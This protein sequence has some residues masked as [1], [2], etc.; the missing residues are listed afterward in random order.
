V[1]SPTAS[2]S[3]AR[4]RPR[5]A[6][7]ICAAGLAALIAGL[8]FLSGCSVQAGVE[9]T[10]NT[11]LSGTVGI[12]LV[13]D[14]QLQDALSGAASGLGGR[15]GAILGILGDLGGLGGTPTSVDDL[16]SLILGQIPGEWKVERGTDSSGARWLSLTRPFSSP[17]ELQQILSGRLISAVINTDGFSLTQDKGFFATKTAYSATGDAGSVTSRVQ[18]ATGLARSVLGDVFTVQNRVTLP[19]T[20]D[21]NNAD[22][23]SGNMLV[24]NLGTSGAKDMHAS[25]TIYRWGAIA[26]TAIL[27]VAI[28]AAIIITAILVARRRR[29]PKPGQP[30]AIEPGPVPVQTIEAVGPDAASGGTDAEPKATVPVPPAPE[31]PPASPPVPKEPVAPPPAPE[32]PPASPPVPEEPVAPPPVSEQPAAVA[33]TAAVA[34]PDAPRPVVPIPLRPTKAQ[35]VGYS[36]P[37]TAPE[38]IEQTSEPGN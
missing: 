38:A 31:E 28:L 15:A 12:R 3:A 10:V 34:E 33:A 7:A 30:G 27:G 25:S 37:G 14:K 8:V 17:E 19:G 4:R 6:V 22:E 24:W 9:T 13:A 18:S 11:D 36:A 26:G 2:L 16:F 20:I 32:E 29:K 1:N 23:V 21:D 5:L 35:P